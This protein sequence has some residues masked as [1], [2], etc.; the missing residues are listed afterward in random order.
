MPALRVQILQVLGYYHGA[1]YGT[2]EAMRVTDK[3]YLMRLG[4]NAYVDARENFQCAARYINDC[5]REGRYNVRWEK[6]PE[7][8]HAQAIAIKPIAAG[9]ELFVN[10]GARYWAGFK[11]LYKQEPGKLPL[12]A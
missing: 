5:R 1:R 2:A 9:D 4:A 8:W 6:Q 12:D 7:S 3:S 11:L 10:Y